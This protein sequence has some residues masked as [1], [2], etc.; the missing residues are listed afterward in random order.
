MDKFIINGG[1]ELNGVVDI[2]CA[3]NAYLPILAACILCD[4]VV[5]LH[6]CP[7]YT[8]ITN[9]CKILEN[10]GAKILLKENNDLIIDARAINNFKIPHELG[11]KIRSSIF[12]LG[13]ILG[14]CGRAYVGYPGGCEIGTRPID[15]HLKGLRALNVEIVD[16]HGYLNCNS[17][18]LKGATI[19]LDMPSVGATENIMLGAVLAK[20]TTKIINCAREPEIVD[21]QEFLKSMGA[22]IKGAGTG[23]ITIKG[24]S[25]LHGTEYTPIPDRII[26]GTMLLASVM[27]KGKVKLNNANSSHIESLISKLNNNSCKIE[28]NRDNI[29]IE[30]WARPYSIRKIETMPYPGFPTDLQPQMM[31][32]QCI[33]KG[34]SILVENLFEARFKHVAELSKM[35]ADI[36]VK[37]RTAVIKGVPK[38][39]GGV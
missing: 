14:R 37:D 6:K 31:A 18:N 22:K 8:D 3:K 38:L 39:F 13:A 24:V 33:S 25:R 32:M 35:G 21:L 36:V 23:V 20:G 16:R 9:M 11:S 15:L 17:K 1:K 12:S 10:L 30:S 26:T 2:P 19:T 4:G 5:T 34:T 27:T 29:E 28:C 7:K